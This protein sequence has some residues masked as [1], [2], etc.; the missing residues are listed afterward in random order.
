MTKEE[1]IGNKEERLKRIGGSEFGT[2]MEVNPYGKR[3]DLVLEKAGVIASTF[4]GNAATRRGEFLEDEVIAMFEDETGMSVTDE[5]AEFIRE[6]TQDCLELRCHV[7]GIIN[8][9]SA[10]FEA[11]TTD[12]KAKTWKDGIPEGYKAQLEFNCYLAKKKKAYIAVGICNGEEIVDFKWFPY[13]PI[14]TEE[15][16][17]KYC[18]DFTRD[19]E[20]YKSLG[21]I[22][23]GKIIKSK[24]DDSLIEELNSL[25]EKIS[26]IKA[27]A[28]EFEDKKK[29]I[30][31]KIKKEIGNNLGIETDL[32]KI[33][34]GNRVTSPIT[35]YKVSR[36]G[37]KI[38]YK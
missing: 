2:I 38:E 37:I 11:K 20:Y 14:M 35:E 4:E 16:I 30:E 23:N 25:N 24:L 13:T 7:D 31:D 33:T 3:I 29:K 1:I 9:G 10:V 36:S 18:I 5:Q 32:F 12:I 22:N 8:N 17:L 26:Q 15:E 21:E 19:V 28:K 27:Q 6:K 34:I